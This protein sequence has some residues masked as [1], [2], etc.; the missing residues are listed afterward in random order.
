MHLKRIASFADSLFGLMK[1]C[2]IEFELHKILFMFGGNT[3]ITNKCLFYIVFLIVIIHM[4][5][6]FIVPRHFGHEQFVA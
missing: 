4:H 3:F 6:V 1:C 5:Q 2:I